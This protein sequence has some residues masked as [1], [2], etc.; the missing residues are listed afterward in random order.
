MS[1]THAHQ[2]D[3]C[4]HERGHITDSRFYGNRY[5]TAASR[6][7]YCDVCRKQ[8]WLDIE[9]ALAQAQGELGMIPGHVVEGIVSAARL[10][11]IDLD[12]VQEEIE[13]SGHSLVGLLRVFQAAC[14]DGTGEF[15]HF[16]ATTQD[17]Q[18]TGQSLEI[19]DTLD[20]IDR[21]LGEILGCLVELAEEHADTV[22][23]GRTHA[24]AALPM[25]FGLK[26]ASWIDEILRHTERLAT[27]RSRVVVAQLF[28][29]A[30][31]MAGF[32]T[33][34]IGLLERFA[35]R[36]G[37]GV[38]TI[39][40]HVARDRVVEF[41]TTLAMVAGTLGRV[42]DEIRTI[43]RPEFGEVTEPWRYGK[44]GS[45]TMPHK[46]N[47][48][49]CEQVV[50]MAK[51]AAAQAGI[52]YSGMIGDHERDSR[53]LRVEWACVPD[54]SHYTLAACEITRE[55]VSGLTVNVDRLREN[56]RVVADQLASERL[57]LALGAHVG[58]QTA[59]E[60]VY[61]LSQQAHDAGGSLRE[62]LDGCADL[63]RLL[64]DHEVEVIFDPARYLGASTDLTHRAV[65]EARKWLAGR[66]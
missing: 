27:V 3:T 33:E 4:R 12:A 24:R 53:A 10:E 15:I 13:R 59:H 54:V 66:G 47:P 32:G 46:R 58:K 57:M 39:G 23:V 63:R 2:A 49:R 18:D 30:G 1:V 6:R 20:E 21:E 62:S 44:V 19:R 40:W 48:E 31:T 14:P 38:P 56:T 17:I 34:G 35:A 37:L 52:A 42:A 50:V 11:R 64:P 16:G 60:R 51:L 43:G 8:R 26:A 45:S 9:A 7:I 28:G 41:V 29:G 36:L 55:L 65:A 22:A 25:S 61:E 5:A